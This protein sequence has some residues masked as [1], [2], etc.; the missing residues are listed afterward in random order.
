MNG[1]EFC[2][3][4]LTLCTWQQIEVTVLFHGHEMLILE[5]DFCLLYS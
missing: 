1:S 3:D 2:L 5:G 4:G